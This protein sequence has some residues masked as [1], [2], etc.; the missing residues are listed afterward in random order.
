MRNRVKMAHRN[1][2]KPKGIN[3]G[4]LVCLFGKGDN[5]FNE[6]QMQVRMLLLMWHI[7]MLREKKYSLFGWKKNRLSEYVFWA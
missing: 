2:K 1:L 4:D 7:C 3:E 5:I 6:I